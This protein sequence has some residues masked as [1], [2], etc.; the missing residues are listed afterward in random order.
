MFLDNDGPIPVYR[1]P[2]SPFLCK[3]IKI[4]R[5]LR[6]LLYLCGKFRELFLES[7]TSV[8]SCYNIAVSES[9][10]LLV[11]MANYSVGG[12]YIL[13]PTIQL[14]VSLIGSVGGV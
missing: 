3:R 1:E 11:R 7:F 13:F 9:L 2:S 12:M 14:E 10:G 6:R 8:E 4:L 5:N